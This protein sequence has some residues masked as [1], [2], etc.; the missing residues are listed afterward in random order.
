[1]SQKNL[2]TITLHA[3]CCMD[4]A[5]VMRVEDCAEAIVGA[6]CRKE[7]CVTEHQWWKLF[8]RFK[9]W[10]P[11]LTQWVYLSMCQRMKKHKIN[12]NKNYNQ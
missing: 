7:K 6:I 10:C 9:F 12:E 5:P 11:E 1:M 4:R 2:L 3:Q 8:F